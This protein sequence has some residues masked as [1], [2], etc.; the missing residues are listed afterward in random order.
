MGVEARDRTKGR[1]ITSIVITVSI[2]E[3]SPA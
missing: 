2:R 3:A 1:S